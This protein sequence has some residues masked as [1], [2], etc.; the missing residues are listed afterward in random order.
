MRKR[1]TCTLKHRGPQCD[2]A[3]REK[4]ETAMDISKMAGEILQPSLISIPV[5]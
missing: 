2:K 4:I 3:R 1:T 5:H